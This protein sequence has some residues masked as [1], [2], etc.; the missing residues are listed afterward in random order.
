MKRTQSGIDILTISWQALDEIVQKNGETSDNFLFRR[1]KRADESL[2]EFIRDN[3]DCIICPKYFINGVDLAFWLNLNVYQRNWIDTAGGIISPLWSSLVSGDFL[4]WA[5][6]CLIELFGEKVDESTLKD[7]GY[8][9]TENLNDWIEEI[10]NGAPILYG[11][12]CGDRQ[13]PC[14]IVKITRTDNFITWNLRGLRGFKFEF[15]SYKKA[16]KDFSD[17]IKQRENE[18]IMDEQP[19]TINTIRKG[20]FIKV[21]EGLNCP[22]LEY[23]SMNN[24]QGEVIDID[25]TTQLIEIKWD[26]KSLFD[27]PDKYLVD[28]IKDGYDYEFATLEIKDLQRIK[29]RDGLIWEEDIKKKLKEKLYWIELYED[30]KKSTTY[31]NFFEGI[32]ATNYI[33]LF[34]RWEDYLMANLV[35]PF[36]AMVVEGRYG[37]IKN[38]MKITLFDVQDYNE[39]HG[40]YCIGKVNNRSVTIPIC[41]LEANDKETNNYK[42]LRDYAIWFANM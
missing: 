31:Y 41:N 35:F 32:D 17:A 15:E 28:L 19:L 11:C 2:L 22:N 25:K 36:D 34:K 40:I 26:A 21:K 42:L 6:L 33:A 9:V 13:C 10:N 12:Y 18:K 23:Q 24:W 27:M 3:K 8:E 14:E 39:M 4:P 7:I 16:F 20:C 1:E 29:K 38:G 30:E 5:K 37:N